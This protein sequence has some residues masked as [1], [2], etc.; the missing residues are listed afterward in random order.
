MAR[1]A[2]TFPDLSS[3]IYCTVKL[4]ELDVYRPCQPAFTYKEGNS[5]FLH[6][7]MPQKGTIDDGDSG[8]DVIIIRNSQV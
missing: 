3:L 2:Y 1:Y 6:D 5:G 8:K 4:S 7:L